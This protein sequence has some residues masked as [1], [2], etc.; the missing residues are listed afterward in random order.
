M[1]N[2][3][4]EQ[5]QAIL[6]REPRVTVR[7]SAGSGKTFVLVQRYLH[8]VK[9]H[10][11][12]PRQILTITF[13]RKAAVEMKLRIVKA[14]REE[15]LFEEAQLAETGP[16]ST[17]DSF[18]EQ[19]LRAH[20]LEAGVD[21][22]FEIMGDGSR[23]LFRRAVQETLL[24]PASQTK[25]AREVIAKLVAK[26][27]WG[28]DP[29]LHSSLEQA[30]SNA[31]E[32]IRSQG[33]T[34]GQID[35]VVESEDSFHSWCNE[36]LCNDF[37]ICDSAKPYFANLHTAFPGNRKSD[38][39]DENREQRALELNREFLNLTV[40]IWRRYDHIMEEEQ[41]FDFPAIANRSV[42][43]IENNKEIQT[44]LQE[45]YPVLLIDETQDVNH[46][47]FRLVNSLVNDF[48]FVVGDTQQSIYSFRHAAP[49]LL[50]ARYEETETLPLTANFR[51]QSSVLDFVNE[52][53]KSIWPKQYLAM[54]S[55]PSPTHQKVGVEIWEAI[56][57]DF[58]VM[59]AGIKRLIDSGEKP[60]DITILTNANWESTSASTALNALEIGNVIEGATERFSA[61]MEIRDIA[62]SL[63]AIT[64][65]Y[66][67]F[68]LACLLHSPL[69]GVSPD[70]ILLLGNDGPIIEKLRNWTTPVKDDQPIIERFLEWFEPLSQFADRVPAWEILSEISIQTE[71]MRKAAQKP[72]R[73]QVLANIR[74]LIAEATA[75]PELNASEF[76]QLIH[77]WSLIKHRMSDGL[78]ASDDE[79]KVRIM[80]IHQSKGLEFP[81][82][83]LAP[84]T[85]KRTFG[86]DQAV[87]L[88][89]TACIPALNIDKAF[90]PTREWIKSQ[91]QAVER[92]ESDRKL[93]VALTRAERRLILNLPAKQGRKTNILQ[94]LMPL[95]RQIAERQSIPTVQIEESG[96]E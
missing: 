32:K 91:S 59:A 5:Q 81:V 84:T 53:F 37:K 75:R 77:E 49:H 3:T 60:G 82:V 88:H 74:K 31:L 39:W 33:I 6:T 72:D 79:S 4:L 23:G 17:I 93:Y 57:G 45:Q 80:T 61:R 42:Y 85:M 12:S 18:H 34:L 89:P 11:Y 55:S 62:N 38:Q 40:E 43:L 65:P 95:F 47:Q 22:Q 54:E 7:A 24:A 2:P 69:V 25:N 67:N 68:S 15:G 27:G 58:E 28:Q 1:P 35:Q 13:T 20:A 86:G 96:G 14:L 29:W 50:Q 16:I 10:G 48:E 46:L 73:E 78:V 66:D 63:T 51:T 36:Q 9:E 70:T 8:L 90:S 26:T 94:E 41:S 92:D 71:L 64:N 30:T 83:V 87:I 52:V 56:P 19:F 76:A 44:R 21:P